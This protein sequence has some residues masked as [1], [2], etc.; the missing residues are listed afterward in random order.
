MEFFP[1]YPSTEKALFIDARNGNFMNLTW[2]QIHVSREGYLYA[3]NKKGEVQ[4]VQW[5]NHT[6][7]G[8][9]NV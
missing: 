7:S 2:S 6:R 8:G 3:Q 9:R 4:L 1:P 5:V